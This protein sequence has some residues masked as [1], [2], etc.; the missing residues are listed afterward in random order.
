MLWLFAGIV[1]LA[2]W[3][4][5]FV[6]YVEATDTALVIQNPLF[7][8]A[9]AWDQIARVRSGYNGLVVVARDGSRSSAWA[10]QKSNIA[11]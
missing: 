3:R 9:Y 2:S 6:P 7:K 4:M 11:S 5:A 8:K 1:C 10:V